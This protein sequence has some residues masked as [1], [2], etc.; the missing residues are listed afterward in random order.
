MTTRERLLAALTGQDVDHTPMVLHFWSSPR[1][2]RAVWTT[3]RERLGFYR[4]QGWDTYVIAGAGVS[5]LSEVTTATAFEVNAGQ[6]VFCQTWHTPAGDLHERLRVT[7]D[8]LQEL[9]PRHPLLDDFRTARYLEYP[10]KTTSDLAALPYLFPRHNPADEVAM[11]AAHAPARALA[12]EFAVPLV[13]YLPDGLDWLIW[14]FPAQEAVLR[15]ALEPDFIRTLLASINAA[16]Q[17]RLG[18]LLELGVDAVLRRGWY[19]STDFWSPSLYTQFAKPPLLAEVA[20]THQA[21]IPFIYQMDSGIMPLLDELASVPFDCLLGAD[22]ATSQQDSHTIR[23]RLPGKALWGGLSGPLQLGMGTPADTEAAVAR[24]FVVCGN[25]G[26]VL[27]PGVGIRHQWPWEN[28]A[29]CDRAWR[30]LR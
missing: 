23:E 7:G 25:R 8:W 18:L 30:R 24:A 11:A 22:P 17:Q 20:A 1:H 16:Y 15:A 3:E 29:A 10:F 5:P 12:D 19:E 28:I 9:P 26:F 4:Q 14:L 2:P 13:G 27:G 21:G 6:R